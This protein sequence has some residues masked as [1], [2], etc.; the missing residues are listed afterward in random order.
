MID[1]GEMGGEKERER[2]RGRG[3]NIT[4]ENRVARRRGRKEREIES[5]TGECVRGTG[6]KR[7]CSCRSCPKLCR[8]VGERANGV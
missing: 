7:V 5:W 1:Q 3:R 4:D 6:R 2:E 8:R